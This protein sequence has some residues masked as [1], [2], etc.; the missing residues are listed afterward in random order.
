M[1][2]Q[3]ADKVRATHGQHHL[4]R[5]ALRQRIE[6][7]QQNGLLVDDHDLLMHHVNFYDQ[8]H[9][10]A[11]VGQEFLGLLLALQRVLRVADK[12]G[13]FDASAGRVSQDGDQRPDPGGGPGRPDPDR[14]L[15]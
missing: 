10:G 11:Q 15:C 14:V 1:L 7:A 8:C 3:L 2:Q 13:D 4:A 6:A 9:N 5:P 12:Y